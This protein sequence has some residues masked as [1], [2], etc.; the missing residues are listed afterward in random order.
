M[1]KGQV[2]KTEGDD[3]FVSSSKSTKSTKSLSK[4]IKA[5]EKE[6]K[7]LKKSV[8]LQ[9]HDE[10]DDEESDES[11]ISSTKEGSSHFQNALEMLEATHPK[12]VLALKHELVR[13]LNDLDLQNV[14]LL[15]NQS[16]FNLCC[17]KK[18]TLK[19]LKATNTLHMKRNGGGLKITEQCEIPGY[20]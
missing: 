8:A 10:D 12:I 16:T 13:K 1:Q 19:I 6:N 17:N 14:L 15:D 9:Q 3:K 11:S 5:L 18:F 20:K 4:T 2:K 7:K